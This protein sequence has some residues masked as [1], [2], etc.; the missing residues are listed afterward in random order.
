[1]N[2]EEIKNEAVKYFGTELAANVWMSKYALRKDTQIV[3]EHPLH[4]WKRLKD[5]IIRIDEHYNDSLMSY[6]LLGDMFDNMDIVL[7]GS[8]IFGIGN[9]NTLTS[10]GNCFVIGNGIDSYGG[11]CTTD[12]E[13]IQLMKR[14][15]GV[16]HDLSHIR[17]AGSFVNNAAGTSTGIVPFMERYSNS[18]REVAQDGRRGALMLTLDIRHPDAEAFLMAK[19]NLTKITGANISFKVTNAFM[20]AVINDTTFT[21]Q[22]PVDSDQPMVKKVINARELWNKIMVQTHK[23]AEPGVIFIDKII[24][25]SPADIYPQFKTVSTNPCGE[26][27]LCE[28]DSCRLLAI[29]LYNMVD[30]PFT[31]DAKINI[32]KLQKTAYYAQVIMDNIID[33]EK[34]KID[35]ILDKLHNSKEPDD[36]KTI[37]INLWQKIRQKL[38]LGRRTGIGIMGL[39]DMFA[40]IG[41]QYGSDASLE[42]GESIQEHIS[43]NCYEASIDMA[44]TRGAFPLCDPELEI[45]HPFV[46][47][48]LDRLST[49]YVLDFENNGRRNIANLTIAP[50]GTIS[51]LAG[52][53]SGIE[54][55]FNVY[56]ERR[57]KLPSAENSDYRDELGDYWRTYLVIHPKFK[58]W[59]EEFYGHSKDLDKYTKSELDELIEISPY[60]N[61]AAHQIDPF[62]KIVLQGRMQ[63]WIDHSI[64]V[65]HNLPSTVTVEEVSNYYLSAYQHGCKGMTIYRDGSRDGVLS[66]NHEKKDEFKY[67]D[68]PKRPVELP[69]ELHHIRVKGEKYIVVIG[70]MDNKPYEIFC[71]KDD[72]TYEETKGIIRKIRKKRFDYVTENIGI[73]NLQLEENP[74]H[75]MVTIYTSMLLRHGAKPEFILH[76]IDK[77]D[78]D[79]NSI[80]S[81]IQRILK[82]YIED[83]TVSHEKCTECGE[84]MIY[85]GGCNICPNCGN[86]KC[87]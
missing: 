10:L 45:N 28:Y 31:L 72:N 38:L 62:K 85:E 21:Q 40:A 84:K 9:N 54:P 44:E 75:R 13:Q 8:N 15:G 76:A 78:L 50:T 12:Q 59:F 33:L 41:V 26:L 3:E 22:F 4:T 25:E 86:S 74:L 32:V 23:S 87:S 68:A 37:E 35:A 2:I 67:H 20:E 43:C 27:P 47:R 55:V 42:I 61:S 66:I 19:N 80:V 6:K 29:N 82:K 39:G 65:T 58:V 17:P 11:I 56:H 83:G 77:F 48:I 14:R 30:K 16:G 57:T 49:A 53:T 36:I 70:F 34:E 51:L 60:A 71:R 24:E 18:T 52:V 63:K 1:M 73:P 5:E 81:A 46:S 69:A 79:I 7:G 64:S